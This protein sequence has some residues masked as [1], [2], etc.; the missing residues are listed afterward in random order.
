MLQPL[1]HSHFP[2][3]TFFLVLFS[4]LRPRRYKIAVERQ[5]SNA[6]LASIPVLA[7][8]GYLCFA[9]G[10]TLVLSSMYKLGILGTYLGDHFGILKDSRI[11]SFPFNVVEHPMYVGSTLSFLSYAL[12]NASPA[13]LFL[14]S[15]VALAY[16]IAGHFEGPFTSM[17]YARAAEQPSEGKKV[18]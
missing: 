2:S 16:Y 17:I 13:G 15:C 8:L 18:N 10:Q 7:P 1:W 11:T 12:T 14:T 3:L 9:A 5:Q 4:F 6:F